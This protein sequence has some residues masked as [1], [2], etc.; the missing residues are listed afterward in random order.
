MS[1]RLVKNDP[2]TI[3]GFAMYDWAN[4]AYI[5]TFG[6]VIGF[7]F[8]DTIVPDEGYWGMDGQTLWAFIVGT[9]SLLLFIVMPV[10]GTVT[11]YAP[12]KKRFLR[13]FAVLGA[14]TTMGLAFVPDDAVGW[15]LL[16]A[17]ITNIFFVAANVFY[18][19]FLPIITTD[20]TIDEVSS[21]GFAY[22][23]IGGGIYLALGAAV[24]F[25]SDSGVIGF[26]ETTAFRVVIGGAGLWWLGFSVVSLIRLTEDE[27]VKEMPAE[28]REGSRWAAYTRLGFREVW[29]TTKKLRQF[30]AVLLFVIAFFLYSN[31]INTV[32]AM[33]G[34]YAADTLR[35]TQTDVII[36]FLIV[37][38]VAFGGALFFGWLANR[39]GTKPAIVISLVIW[40]GL[41]IAGF[42]LPAEQSIPF[43]A[44]GAG[45]GLVLG[46]S[47]ALSRSL[48]GS[49]IPEDSSAEFFGFFTVFSKASAI[50][51]AWAFAITAALTGE[52]RLAILSVIVFFIS[53]LL[54]LLRV[55][56][57]EGR[58]SRDE[59]ATVG[60]EAE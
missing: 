22:G 19:S 10:L 60:A 34:P 30:R 15:F 48:Y 14:L 50:L 32:I 53:G 56:V 9:A 47:Q 52:G 3:W 1:Q 23:Y 29:A 17:L 11:D 24:I 25:L 21:K 20:E 16:V 43:Y 5:T 7:F 54:V 46:G 18:D 51:G 55:D 42:L 39:I 13:N 28:F 36:T 59:W 49:M 45:V 6:A 8:A 57:E 2:R 31:G 33:S 58:A 27:D 12:A 38:F 40:S 4:S 41:A 35:L 37:Q 26:S 44:L